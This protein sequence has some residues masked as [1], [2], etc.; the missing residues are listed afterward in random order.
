MKTG[1]LEWGKSVGQTAVFSD[2]LGDQTSIHQQNM[3]MGH[4]DEV[5]EEML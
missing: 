4:V 3:E 2:F 1:R 5:R